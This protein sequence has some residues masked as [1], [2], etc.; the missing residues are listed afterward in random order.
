MKKFLFFS[1]LL[2]LSTSCNVNHFF[3][4]NEGQMNGLD[5]SKGKWL[6]GEI[7][8]NPYVK[9]NLTNQVR[10]DF[11][12][13]LDDRVKY[14]LEEKSLLIPSKISLNP[15][16]SAIINLKKGINNYDYYINIKCTNGRNDL[17]NF[18]YTQHNYYKKQMSFSQVTLEVYDLNRGEIIYTQSAGGYIDED[19]SP[20]SRPTYNIIMG[21]YNKIMNDIRQKSIKFTNPI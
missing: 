12:E 13:Y 4:Y 7:E 16:K 15:S 17:S 20:T 6:I 21:C 9:D 18:D 8:V 3:L 2:L 10:I 5:F 11:S 1:L 14:S 19:S